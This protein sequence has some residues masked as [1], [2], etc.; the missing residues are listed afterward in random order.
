MNKIKKDIAWFHIY[1]NKS[2]ARKTK[3]RSEHFLESM[4]LAVRFDN[5]E[6]DT[7]LLKYDNDNYYDNNIKLTKTQ[8]CKLIYLMISNKNE[9][10]D[11]TE[12][13]NSLSTGS[14]F[15]VSEES[16]LN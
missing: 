1:E 8:F 5:D 4:I 6:K 3:T 12:N 9:T 10:F 16:V 11:N 15:Y 13:L 14:T 7:I 2:R